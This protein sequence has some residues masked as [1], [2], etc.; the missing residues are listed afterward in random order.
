V[1]A[2]DSKL[3]QRIEPHIRRVLIVDPSPLASRMLG[4]L[5][6][7]LG[8][9]E[10]LYEPDERRALELAATADPSIIFVEHSGP[11]LQGETFT[12]R[13]RRSDY[14][15]RKAPVIMVT[16]DA[17][18]STIKGA[19][20]SGVHEFLRKP[21][22]AG[23]LVRRIEA[24]TLK[25]RDWIEAV[26][27]VG[28]DRRRFNSGEYSGQRKRRSDKSETA[29]DTEARALD[30][31]VRILKSAIAQYDADPLQARRAIVG[32][33]P[34]LKQK[35][36]ATR[37]ARL[38]AAVAELEVAAGQPG[39]TRAALVEPVKGVLDLFEANAPVKAA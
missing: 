3:L 36:I 39:A 7:G 30:Q 23:D 37:S 19:R 15:C 1:F 26:Q 25:P 31:A 9:R 21:F 22:T 33:T 4:D 8:A 14:A 38:A 34:V 24:V 10:F 29:A 32:Q 6:R 27:Y 16:A 11:R 13:L 28:P 35:A 18:A 5:M 17:T 12:R 20:D 2:A